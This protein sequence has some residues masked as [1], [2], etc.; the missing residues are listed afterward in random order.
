MRFSRRG[1]AFDMTITLTLAVLALLLIGAFLSGGFSSLSGKTMA[2]SAES[3]SGATNSGQIVNCNQLCGAI[4]SCS[5]TDAID[6]FLSAGCNDIIDSCEM[7]DKCSDCE[8][9]Y[10]ELC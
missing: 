8:A 5:E 7:A 4:M 3:S 10:P 1:M 9:P 2:Y 6:R